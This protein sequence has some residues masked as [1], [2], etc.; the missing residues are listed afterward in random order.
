MP[1]YPNDLQTEETYEECVRLE[2]WE[3]SIE[4]L[5]QLMK[6]PKP[7]YLEFQEALQRM[8]KAA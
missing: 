7:Y 8:K 1:K 3:D 6:T 2:P 4:R 5:A